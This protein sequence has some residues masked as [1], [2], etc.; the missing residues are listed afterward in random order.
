MTS[1]GGAG[2]GQI[3]T[4]VTDPVSCNVKTQR[5]NEISAERSWLVQT[6]ERRARHTYWRSSG[7]PV[8]SSWES[9]QGSKE[10][11]HSGEFGLFP[12]SPHLHCY[13]PGPHHCPPA[14]PP[15]PSCS[16][17]RPPPPPPPPPRSSRRS[18]SPPAEPGT[19]RLSSSSPAAAPS[20]WQ[21]AVVTGFIK[22]AGRTS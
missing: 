21:P 7:Q 11:Y 1:L 22:S 6:G 14:L 8:I 15:L 16:P 10:F 2:G 5:E 19:G 18:S 12:G 13:Q 4:A 20:P 3:L 9:W 17:P